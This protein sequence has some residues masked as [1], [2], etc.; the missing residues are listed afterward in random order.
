MKSFWVTWAKT[1]Y[2]WDLTQLKIPNMS[3]WFP[4][5]DNSEVDL[6]NQPV[7]ITGLQKCLT[8][9]RCTQEAL[10]HQSLHEPVAAGGRDRKWQWFKLQ[11]CQPTACFISALW[12]LL[13]INFHYFIIWL[14]LSIRAA[15]LGLGT[16]CGLSWNVPVHIIKYICWKWCSRVPRA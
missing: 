1:N 7:L 12:F 11:D 9:Q 16:H 10:C 15:W 4:N 3:V 13:V 2:W 8:F 6:K 14:G 5:N